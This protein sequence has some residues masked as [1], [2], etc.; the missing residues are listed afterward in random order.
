MNF[1]SVDEPV[2]LYGLVTSF[3]ILGFEF[4]LPLKILPPVNSL[5]NAGFL[6]ISGDIISVY[7]FKTSMTAEGSAAKSS[8]VILEPFNRASHSGGIPLTL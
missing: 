4:C 2:V 6:L 7:V 1:K 3:K 5:S 8:Y